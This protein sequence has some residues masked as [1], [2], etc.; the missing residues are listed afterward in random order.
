V[1]TLEPFWNVPGRQLSNEFN[2]EPISKHKAISS[3]IANGG[4]V[5]FTLS[6]VIHN[7]V[8]AYK[9]EEDTINEVYKG[10]DK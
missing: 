6:R 4:V 9:I 5:S 8:H 1:L 10:F 3:K 2:T 7:G